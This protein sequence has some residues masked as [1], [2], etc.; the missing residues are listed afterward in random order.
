[1]IQGFDEDENGILDN[2]EL[3]NWRLA[4]EQMFSEWNWQP[5]PEYMAGVKQAWHDQG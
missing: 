2:T 3:T 1:M 4:T 5:S